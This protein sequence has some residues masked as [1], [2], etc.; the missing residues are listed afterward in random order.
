MISNAQLTHG[1][2]QSLLAKLWAPWNPGCKP[3]LLLLKGSFISKITVWYAVAGKCPTL[4]SKVASRAVYYQKN[5]RSEIWFNGRDWCRRSFVLGIKKVTWF[6]GNHTSAFVEGDSVEEAAI[7]LRCETTEE[8]CFTMGGNESKIVSIDALYNFYV[9]QINF[10]Q[11]CK[12]ASLF[13]SFANE[14]VLWRV[15]FQE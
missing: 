15:K 11:H 10:D 3:L 13:L 4:Y 1:P 8:N 12:R 9:H 7:L 6:R 2:R 14:L 5:R